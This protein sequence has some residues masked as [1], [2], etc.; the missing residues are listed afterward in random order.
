MEHDYA[1]GL[2]DRSLTGEARHYKVT[3]TLTNPLD[4]REVT[5][6]SAVVPGPLPAAEV[7]L[8]EQGI[9]DVCRHCRP[10]SRVEVQTLELDT[11]RIR[12]GYGEVDAN[13]TEF[14]VIG[15]HEYGVPRTIT[16]RSPEDVA[17]FY[18]GSIEA[19]KNDLKEKALSEERTI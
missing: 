4:I 9:E 13:G 10:D 17:T 3:V 11:D 19:V 2:K 15:V 7:A 1:S 14:E 18:R 12:P 8:F 16:A 5:L 6:T